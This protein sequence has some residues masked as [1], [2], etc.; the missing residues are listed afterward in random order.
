MV[1]GDSRHT[2]TDMYHKELEELSGEWDDLDPYDPEAEM[3][4]QYYFS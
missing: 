2:L 1:N 3:P 4:E